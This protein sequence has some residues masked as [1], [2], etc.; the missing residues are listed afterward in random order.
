MNEPSALLPGVA[1]PAVTWARV[2]LA[3]TLG[4]AAVG[5]VAAGLIGNAIATALGTFG[6]VQLLGPVSF[7]VGLLMVVASFIVWFRRAPM[8]GT[9]TFDEHRLHVERAGSPP[10]SFERSAITSA[11]TL[12]RYARGSYAS[13]VEL[14][15]RGGD[16]VSFEAPGEE[17][18]RAIVLDLGFGRGKKR[19]HMALGTPGRRLFHILIG[20]AAY[21][22]GC[23]ATFPFLLLFGFG[24]GT[25]LVSGLTS[26]VAMVGM[27]TFL[28]SQLRDP[29]VTV[30]DDGIYYR[31]GRKK[32]FLSGANITGV[33]QTSVALPLLIHAAQGTPIA[34]HGSALDVERRA[35]LA[36]LVQERF[37]DPSAAIDQNAAQFA[38]GGRTVAAW[39]EHLR[40]HVGNVGYREAG[41]PS[42][43]AAAVLHS[44]RSTSEERAGAALALR[45]SGEPEE[46]IRVAASAVADDEL[47]VALEAIAD[48]SDDVV[49]ERALR[50]LA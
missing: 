4:R 44:P 6:M 11:Y 36:L 32:R 25:S 46:R 34:I 45:V 19:T 2:G 14:E 27:Y 7:L 9:V 22:F 39:R 31:A 24:G 48:T 47:R 8:P 35:A 28:K 16:V 38:R 40:V 17:A 15:L 5:S 37:M 21:T 18:A 50:K 3:K 12:A 1:T 49:L 42:D 33:T 41:S 29:E 10:R 20:L 30:G 43:V 23:L 13:V 26:A